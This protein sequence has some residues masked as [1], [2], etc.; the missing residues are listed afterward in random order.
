[1]QVSHETIC[2]SLLCRHGACP[3]GPWITSAS[4]I[5]DMQALGMKLWVGDALMQDSNTSA[6]IFTEE[7]QIPL[8]S[9][10]VTLQPG[11]PVLTGTPA[12]VSMPR[13]RFVRRASSRTKIVYRPVGAAAAQRTVDS[14]VSA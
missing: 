8:L 3:I 6:M 10:H 5:G 11:D 7:E 12:G 4:D 1:M 2:R 9:R 14:P 13:N